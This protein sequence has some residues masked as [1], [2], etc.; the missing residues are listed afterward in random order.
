[1]FGQ[2]KLMGQTYIRT[3]NRRTRS[4]NMR[5]NSVKVHTKYV[6]F[7]LSVRVSQ[8][9]DSPHHPIDTMVLNELKGL[10]YSFESCIEHIKI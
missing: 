5:K 3:D 10:Y 8:V 9:R 2:E 1:M 6:F 4:E 7:F